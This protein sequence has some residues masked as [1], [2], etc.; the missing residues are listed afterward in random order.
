MTEY[1]TYLNIF[2]V[3]LSQLLTRPD[4]DGKMLGGF[5]RWADGVLIASAA[6][7]D[8]GADGSGAREAPEDVFRTT[9]VLQVLFHIFRDGTRDVLL[10]HVDLVLGNI[11]SAGEYF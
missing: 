10:K 3:F 2:F 7:N 4:M 8:G 9:G 1:L 11:L 6:A 5:L